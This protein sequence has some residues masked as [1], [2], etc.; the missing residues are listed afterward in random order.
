MSMLSRLIIKQIWNDK[1]LWEGF[2]K[3]CKIT[4]PHSLPILIQLPPPQ[5]ESSLQ[6]EPSLRE[7]LKQYV[8]SNQNVPN[9]IKTTLGL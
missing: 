2:V 6:I 3:C 7:T 9:F 1:R 8:Q 4:L 5:L